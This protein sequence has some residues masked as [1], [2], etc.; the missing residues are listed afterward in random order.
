MN[1]TAKALRGYMEATGISDAK[2]LSARLGINLRTIYR[3]KLDI[4]ASMSSA[5]GGTA[6]SANSATD[7]TL[8]ATGG[9]TTAT[10]GTAQQAVCA[11]DGTK[12]GVPSRARIESPSGILT[13][14]IVSE[15]KC[16]DAQ[17]RENTTTSF[18]WSNAFAVPDDNPGVVFVDGKLKLVNGT[19]AEWEARFGSDQLD[20]ALIEIQ[21]CLQA[22][23][24]TPLKAQVERHLAQ[25]AR[26]KLDRDARYR[27]AVAAKAPPK[28]AKPYMARY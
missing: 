2:E 7:G 5:T 1:N 12:P 8:S 17:A 10:D 13:P 3:L 24:R 28:A 14:K 23:S 9:T 4:A 22:N 25:R 26:E 18:S 16:S 27:A 11:T 6:N 20:L 15:V 21:A 19:R